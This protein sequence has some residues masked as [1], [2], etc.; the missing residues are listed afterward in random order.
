MTKL[1]K[2]RDELRP[3]DLHWRP[4][5]EDFKCG[6]HKSWNEGWDECATYHAEI[7]QELIDA[8]ELV[9]KG[10]TI[11]KLQHNN[12]SEVVSVKNEILVTPETSI[13][14]AALES[15]RNKL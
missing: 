3:R 6:A 4:E 14:R 10:H 9:A 7:I 12:F 1:E 13:A 8:L 5:C 2:M 11:A 15:V